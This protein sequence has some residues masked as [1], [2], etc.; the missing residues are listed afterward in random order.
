ML[1]DPRTLFGAS[2]QL[3][4]LSVWLVAG[5][6]IPILERTTLPFSK[7]TRN[8]DALGYD[9]GLAPRV[10]QFRLD[11]RMIAA[12][13]ARF[14]G[15]GVAKFT[16]AA[17]T[18]LA[19]GCSDA[20]LISAIM[21]LG[22]ALPMAYYF[23]RATIVGLPTNMLVIPL[24]EL[25]MPA[26]I[27][28]LSLSFISAAL[29]TIPALIAGLAIRGIA[30]TVHWLGGFRVADARVATPGLSIIL[31]SVAALGMGL[32]LARKSGWLAAASLVA[33]AASAFWIGAVRP[34][35]QVKS[36]V[37]EMT[38]IDVGQGDSLL[39]VSPQ[40]RTLLI[41][42]GGLP[43]WMNSELDIGENVVSPYLWSRKLQDVDI[44]AITHAHS[45]HIGG[46]AQFSRTSVL[47]SCGWE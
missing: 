2:F 40:G 33:L 17:I 41:D 6:G 28:S 19:L 25:L 15:G 13:L 32:F 4:F 21:Q 1:F 3:T 43:Y 11:L 26:A 36:G 46:W 23:H 27:L 37:L 44:V 35:A 18:R 7:G 9:Y 45:D 31:I 30:G 10:A 22:L 20:F 14:L 24:M 42:A 16:V 12:R 29:A 47:A 5:V 34:R 8:L 38:A 39:V